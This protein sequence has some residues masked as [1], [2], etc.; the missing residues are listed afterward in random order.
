MQ[1]TISFLDAD[2]GKSAYVLLSGEATPPALGMRELCNG[3]IQADVTNV[4]NASCAP[5]LID[6]APRRLSFYST[7]GIIDAS[8]DEGGNHTTKPHAR[9]PWMDKLRAA[10]A[11][12]E[13]LKDAVVC[14]DMPLALEVH[15]TAFRFSAL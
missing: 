2:V 11:T 3:S 12:A 14:I 7:S 10:V 1:G 4:I 6:N 15:A 5:V 8:I 9:Q 13:E